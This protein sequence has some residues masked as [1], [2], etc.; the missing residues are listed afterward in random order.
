MI[1]ASARCLEIVEQLLRL[2]LRVI[3]QRGIVGSVKRYRT[4]LRSSLHVVFL[5]A[6]VT[7][8]SGRGYSSEPTAPQHFSTV[9]TP[10][11]PPA[12]QQQLGAAY[13]A[14]NFHPDVFSP[15][16]NSRLNCEKCL[17][18]RLHLALSLS[19]TVESS[20]NRRVI[21]TFMNLRICAGLYRTLFPI[22]ALLFEKGR[23]AIGTKSWDHVAKYI[24]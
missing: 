11:H 19:P 4:I 15:L 5:V 8:F 24:T 21:V 18:E 7:R 1:F 9:H 3:I 17:L 22:V 20:Y 6:S 14:R 10:T 2:R 16:Q 12:S 13:S 23:C